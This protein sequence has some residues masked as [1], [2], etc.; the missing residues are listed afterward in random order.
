MSLKG[1]TCSQFTASQATLS[2]FEGLQKFYPATII[3]LSISIIHGNL[4]IIININVILHQPTLN[5][6]RPIN[7][8]FPEIPHPPIPHANVPITPTLQLCP[9]Y[10][11]IYHICSPVSLHTRVN[12][13][14]DQLSTN[15]V[16]VAKFHPRY[17]SYKIS[18]YNQ[19]HKVGP[20][21]FLTSTT[22]FSSYNHTKLPL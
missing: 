15:H 11:S 20:T 6:N 7:N 9:L 4:F 2:K 5:H 12:S 14:F 10:I 17:N 21:D 16:N 8:T 1:Q 3:Y 22:E 13:P 19:W 18:R